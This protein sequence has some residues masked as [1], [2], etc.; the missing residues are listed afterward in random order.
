MAQRLLWR[1]TRKDRVQGAFTG[2]G[3][4]KHGGRWNEKG[5]P[6]VYTAESLAGAMVELLAY[7]KDV[8][9]LETRVY[10]RLGVDE[11]LI[12]GLHPN[13]LPDDWRAFPYPPSTQK[14]GTLWHREAPSVGLR[15]PSVLIPET[16]NVLLNPEHP[17]FHRVTIDG[18]YPLAVDGRLA[19]LV[20]AAYGRGG[21]S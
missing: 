6:V 12:L 5:T 21:K 20:E 3:A 7:Y 13:A 1:I 16:Y 9:T 18:P 2:K 15:V 17:E 19:D 14:I 8:R 11:E 4:A 10:F